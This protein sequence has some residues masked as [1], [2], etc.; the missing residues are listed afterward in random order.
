[1]RRRKVEISANLGDMEPPNFTHL[2][3]DCICQICPDTYRKL[4]LRIPLTY[5]DRK[6]VQHG[7]T[8]HDARNYEFSVGYFR[9]N[10][11]EDLENLLKMKYFSIKYQVWQNQV[12][13]F[14]RRLVSSSTKK[15]SLMAPYYVAHMFRRTQ[16]MYDNKSASCMEVDILESC[17]NQILALHGR[18]RHKVRHLVSSNLMQSKIVER[19]QKE[20]QTMK[21]YNTEFSQQSLNIETLLSFSTPHF[22]FVDTDH[23]SQGDDYLRMN[24]LNRFLVAEEKKDYAWNRKNQ[25]KIPGD[26]MLLDEMNKMYFLLRRIIALKNLQKDYVDFLRL[27]CVST[28]DIFVRIDE[29]KKTSILKIDREACICMETLSELEE[30]MDYSSQRKLLSGKDLN[31]T[32]LEIEADIYRASALPLFLDSSWLYGLDSQTVVYSCGHIADGESTEFIQVCLGS[33]RVKNGINMIKMM[34]LTVPF[35]PYS[36]EAC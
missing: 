17:M 30:A 8:Y 16:K 5:Q 2:G 4:K 33:I 14:I 25:S 31:L 6:N 13:K 26:D 7:V 21:K 23:G 9:L 11:Q 1:M 35:S 19:V 10:I 18:L 20:L 15:D 28:R 27:N 36:C 22:D 3:Y 29:A 24:N 12:N 34:Q 32:A